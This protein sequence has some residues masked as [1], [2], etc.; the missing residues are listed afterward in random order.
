MVLLEKSHYDKVIVPL[1]S[2]CIN[3]LFARSVVEH[4]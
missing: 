2:V 4:K 3:N 1:K